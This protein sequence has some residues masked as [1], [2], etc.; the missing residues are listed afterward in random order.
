MQVRPSSLVRASG[1]AL[2]AALGGQTRRTTRALIL[3]GSD[4]AARRLDPVGLQPLAIS[5]SAD[6]EVLVSVEP[7]VVSAITGAASW[8]TLNLLVDA[9]ARGMRLPAPLR[10]ALVG[11]A[12]YAADVAVSRAH[13]VAV[14]ASTSD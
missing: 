11:T 3:A 4:L 10:A 13:H 6:L 5:P 1:A 7:E 14:D 2:A 12:V 9:G 8:A